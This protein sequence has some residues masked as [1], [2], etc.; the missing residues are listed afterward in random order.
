VE[1]TGASVWALVVIVAVNTLFIAALAVALWI[2]KGKLDEALDKITPLVQ[3]GTKTLGQVNEA[4]TRLQHGVDQ[5]L[6]K[7]TVLVDTVAD[8]VDK[9]TAVAEEAVSEPLIGAASVMAGLQRG[10][11]VYSE[12]STA[13]EKATEKGNGQR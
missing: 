11:Q 4:T 8:R 9:T 1:L 5:I 13:V 7:T 12:R 10:L 6:D 2:I 3:Q